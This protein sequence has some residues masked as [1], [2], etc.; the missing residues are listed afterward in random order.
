M[1]LPLYLTSPGGLAQAVPGSVVTL[2][3]P[4]GAVV[5]DSAVL[6]KAQAQ[7]NVDLWA[8]GRVFDA[9]RR[10]SGG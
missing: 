2:T 6:D 7:T 8:D 9:D 4:E 1:S 5:D 3:G 10:V